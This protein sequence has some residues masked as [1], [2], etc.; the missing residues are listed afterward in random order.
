MKLRPTIILFVI[1]I[2]IA[3]YYF[4][5]E[6]PRIDRAGTDRSSESRIPLINPTNVARV[7][8]DRDGD[9]L[10]FAI[11]GTHWEMT[12]PLRDMADQAAIGRL[13]AAVSGAEVF[14]N[15][16][17][18]VDTLSFGLEPPSAV[19]T[20][21][22]AGGDTLTRVEIGDY[23]VDR[24]W[25]YARYQGDILLLPTGLSRY[26]L[27]PLSD[28]RSRR[29][30]TFDTGLVTDFTIYHRTGAHRWQRRGKNWFTVSDGDTI[31]G[32]A[33]AVEGILRRLRGLRAHDFPSAEEVAG[34]FVGD[35]RRIDIT[36]E[37]PGPPI[38]VRFAEGDSGAAF[39]IVSGE[40]RYT[41]VDS[42]VTMIFRL[43]PFDLRDRRV[44][45]FDARQVHRIAIT[46]PDTTATIVR[47][48]D[49]WA[50][51]NPAFGRMNQKRV[52]ALLRRLQTLTFSSVHSESR[53]LPAW[54]DSA[55]S[56]AVSDTRGK[57]I[58]EVQ[59][60]PANGVDGYLI[61]GR[62]LALTARIETGAFEDLVRLLR[63][64]QGRTE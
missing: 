50:H 10:A 54:K 42:S 2:A 26:S 56:V 9:N 64:I 45:H 15:L 63:Q 52:A 24:S 3:S 34:R 23:T 36:R 61:M 19:L 8:I 41:R 6:R 51:P 40:D 38:S 11:Q 32:L 17:R 59:C 16:G 49:A 25:V 62:S 29:V 44:L 55:I 57:I 28:F 4:F 39:A 1:A 37:P 27:A 14:R 35:V 43:R 46:T 30:V 53:P 7:W 18:E 5:V 60:R 31:T 22:A 33:T 20:F 13:I 48:G 58:D 12:F 21:A 47:A